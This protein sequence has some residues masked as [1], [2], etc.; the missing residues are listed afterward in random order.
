[1]RDTELV[2][3]LDQRLIQHLLFL[4]GHIGDQQAEEDHQ[5]LNLP[6]K[7]GVHVVIVDLI[8]HSISG[9]IVC[10]ISMTL[11]Q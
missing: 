8:N 6:G 3:G 7:H 10:R 2:I 4:V 5:L 11:M 9:L 1:M